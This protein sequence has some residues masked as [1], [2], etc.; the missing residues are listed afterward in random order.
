MGQYLNLTA[1]T[2]LKCSICVSLVQ[3]CF[4]KRT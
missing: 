3:F 1:M 2:L 4:S